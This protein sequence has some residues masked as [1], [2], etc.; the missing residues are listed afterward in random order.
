M[1]ALFVAKLTPAAVTPLAPV[2]ASCTVAA[3]LAQVMPSI[4]RTIRLLLMSGA[5]ELVRRRRGAALAGRLYDEQTL[6][7]VHAAPERVFAWLVGRELDGGSLK[8]R[9]LLIDAEALEHDALRAV[10]RFVAVE[11]QADRFPRL[12]DDRVGRVPA[13]HDDANFLD[14]ARA[15]AGG[16]RLAAREE[17]VPQHPDDG[18]GAER[19]DGELGGRHPALATAPAS[20]RRRRSAWR[21]T[22]ARRIP[23]RWPGRR[24]RARDSASRRVA[25]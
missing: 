13:L 14:P 12:D 4:G 6:E 1:A 23:A 20:S 2:S 18:D 5:V 22:T 15:G 17:E 19:R 7:H 11:L 25:P 3:Q 8:R 9:Q 24:P 16:H 10:G 21:R